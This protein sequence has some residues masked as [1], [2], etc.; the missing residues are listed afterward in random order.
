MNKEAKKTEL[1]PQL[2][3]TIYIVGLTWLIISV[4]GLLFFLIAQLP[5]LGTTL[6]LYWAG[7]RSSASAAV[8]FPT[9]LVASISSVLVLAFIAAIL[10]SYRKKALTPAWVVVLIILL[11]WLVS[12]VI[13]TVVWSAAPQVGLG[14]TLTAGDAFGLIVDPTQTVAYVVGALALVTAIG[15]P[16]LVQ[17]IHRHDVK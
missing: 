7:G 14:G 11:S 8:S 17:Y 3:R 2:I 4:I 12:V 10:V 13:A 5:H 9:L 16:A 15:F 1:T 6:W